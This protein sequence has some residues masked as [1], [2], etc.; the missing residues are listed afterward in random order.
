M[1]AAGWTWI[2]IFRIFFSFGYYIT[3]PLELLLKGDWLHSGK[4]FSSHLLNHS[5]DCH[6]SLCYTYFQE[7]HAS[8]YIFRFSLLRIFDNFLNQV[9]SSFFTSF[10]SLLCIVFSIHGNFL[11]VRFGSVFF[12]V[13]CLFPLHI[14]L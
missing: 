9:I 5:F 11:F 6:S 13:S 3:I 8:I 1:I 12:L 4:F 10:S 7:R 14:N 2:A